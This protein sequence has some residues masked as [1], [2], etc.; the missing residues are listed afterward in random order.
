MPVGHVLEHFD[1]D[2]AVEAAVDGEIVHIGG[3][4]REIGEGAAGARLSFDM[5]AFA[6]AEFD[7]AVMRAFGN[8]SA[9]HKD[10]EPQPQPS[11]RIDWPS[12]SA[13]WAASLG[14]RDVLG[15]GQGLVAAGGRGKDEYLR[16][17]PSVSPKNSGGNS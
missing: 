9:I 13:A 1:G 3:D 8:C 6:G 16:R 5:E 2:D 15:F 14:E 17:G 10:S 7:T 11:S 4:D 12:A